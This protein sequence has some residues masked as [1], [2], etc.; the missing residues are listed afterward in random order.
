MDAVCAELEKN[1]TLN[2]NLTDEKTS[3]VS[4]FTS[5]VFAFHRI[6]YY[7]QEEQLSAEKKCRSEETTKLTQ[8]LEQKTKIGALEIPIIQF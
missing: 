7:S 3:L 2:D 6:V 4:R 5:W 8:Q 1:L